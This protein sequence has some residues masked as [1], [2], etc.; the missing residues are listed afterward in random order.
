MTIADL[1]GDGHRDLAVANFGL[2]AVSVLLGNGDGTFGTKS[3]FGAGTNPRS[4]A[5][6][7]FNGDSRL[8]LAIAN[9][10][11]NAVSVNLNRSGTPDAIP[12]GFDLNPNTLNLTSRGLWTTGFL[13]PVPP[14]A[15]GDIDLASIRLN[16]TVP[17]DP[18]APSAV[19]DHDDNGVSDRMVKFNRAALEAI[20]PVG[21]HVPVTVTGMV[22]GRFYSGTDTIRVR[23]AKVTA[24]ARGIRLTAG[25]VTEVRWLTP[26]DVTIQW[27]ALLHSLDGGSTWNLIAQRLPDTGTFD[28]TVPYV[29][30]ERAMVA[31][32]LVESADASGENVEGVLGVSEEFSISAP[33]GVGRPA[34]GRLELSPRGAT[35]DPAPGGRL[36]VD[37]AL[38]DD[39]PARLELADV[40]GR[41]LVA[42]QV[43]ALG[44]GSHALAIPESGG[45]RPGIYFLRLTQ[46][47]SEVRARAVVIR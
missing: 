12:I 1:D 6:A 31:V 10:G 8:D 7:D 33:V 37:I 23:H 35:P 13:E 15:A 46:G 11:T 47:G 44:A 38:R 2:P 43:G 17:V 32:V 26:A 14:F 29:A 9:A 20:V 42:E 16:G 28:W 39:S 41:M 3:D 25:T 27:V 21:D 5:I 24:P 45:L 4:I 30:S 18:S 22:G 36:W 19:G 34:S 40:A